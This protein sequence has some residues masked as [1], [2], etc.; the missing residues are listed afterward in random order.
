MP[1]L[2]GRRVLIVVENLPVPPDRRVWQECLALK[3]AGCTV[4]VICP[5]GRGYDRSY[6]AIDGVHI[7]RHPLPIDA[8]GIAGFVLEYAAAL[9]FQVVLAW[10]VFLTRG[11][12]VIQACNPPDSI[13]IVA[14][15]FRVLFGRKFVFD[16]HD[17]FAALFSVKFPHRPLLHRL[18]QCFERIS[19]RSADRVITTSEALR[20]IAVDQVG[21]PAGRVHLV[22]SCP[23]PRALRR[24]AP[25]PDL[26]RGA[27][28]VAIYLGIM[29]TQDGVDIL[30]RAIRALDREDVHLLLVGDGPELRALQQLAR[31]LGIADRVTFTGFLRGDRLVAA[32]SSADIGVCPDPCNGFNDLLTMNKVLEYMAMELPCVMFDLVEGR[33]I[34]GEAAIHAGRDNDPKSFAQAMSVLFDDPERCR[35]MGETGRR[36]VETKFDWAAHRRVYLDAYASLWR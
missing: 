17:P 1:G 9:F 22:R 27:R 11:F 4:S 19:I 10:R 28:Y 12:D 32:L 2:S 34:A 24:G 14:W 25:D 20:R 31:D 23:D 6:E 7:H 8:R 26:R 29:G 5:K 18:T 13:W 15:P 21:K 35:R 36:R 30:L 3:D 16:H 33:A